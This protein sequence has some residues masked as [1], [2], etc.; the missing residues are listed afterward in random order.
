METKLEGTC[1]LCLEPAGECARRGCILEDLGTYPELIA[2]RPALS[3]RQASVE[4]ALDAPP[5]PERAPIV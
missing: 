2:W 1:P 4:L 3:A 5:A